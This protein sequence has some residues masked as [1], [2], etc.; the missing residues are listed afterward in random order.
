MRGF[1]CRGGRGEAGGWGVE[2]V[3]FFLSFFSG[4]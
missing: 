3:S 1:V 4:F 2:G